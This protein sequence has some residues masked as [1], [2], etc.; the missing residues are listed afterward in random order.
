MTLLST[1][2]R[3]NAFHRPSPVV[4]PSPATKDP[5][6]YLNTGLSTP[7]HTGPRPG[8]T[9]L[10]P[11]FIEQFHELEAYKYIVTS[12]CVALRLITTIFRH[13]KAI[14]I[15]GH[16]LSI[17]ALVAAA[18]HNTQVVLNGS[19][20]VKTRIQRSR[21]VIVGKVEASKSVYGV[22]TGFGGSGKSFP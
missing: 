18:R 3:V 15:D 19:V 4:T 7:P 11:K 5:S 9:N 22:S 14:V 20:E 16:N 2:P 13:G 17:P 21:E 10:L 6:T 8:S 1:E 12:S